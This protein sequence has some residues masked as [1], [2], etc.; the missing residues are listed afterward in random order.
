MAVEKRYAFKKELMQIHKEDLRDPKR[1]PAENEF[2]FTNGTV[3]L[4][5]P[6][7]DPTVTQAARDF[8]A[9]LYTSMGVAVMVSKNPI[10][11]A[12]TVKITLNQNIGAASGY[13]GYRITVEK[14][15]VL[16]EGYDSRGVGQ[17]LYFMEDLMGIRRAPFLKQE[18][19]ARKAVFESR[20]GW[21]AMQDYLCDEEALRWKMR[22]IDYVLEF[23][24]PTFR[25]SN[26]L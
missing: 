10:P 5:P 4:L 14:D 13:M 12:K 15:A 25:K 1:T 22:Q 8:E 24:L 19:I 7:A 16:V 9:F 23:E 2:V 17:G 3:V 26:A 20:L 21:E 6:M 18:V 11:G